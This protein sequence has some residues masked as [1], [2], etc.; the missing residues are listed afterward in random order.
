[1]SNKTAPYKDPKI[2][3]L[4]TDFYD[5]SQSE[6]S[7]QSRA[8]AYRSYLEYMATNNRNIE[9]TLNYPQF[10]KVMDIVEIVRAV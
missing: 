8:L 6:I 7:N 2:I 3:E 1:M 4:F 10:L 5:K 9:L